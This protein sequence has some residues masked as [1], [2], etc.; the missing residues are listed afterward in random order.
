MPDLH[1]PWPESGEPVVELVGPKRGPLKMLGLRMLQLTAQS[2]E[3]R[4]ET[5]ENEAVLDIFGGLCTVNISASA[6]S[7][8]FPE[9]G[10]RQN[11]FA[12]RPTMV[13]I[14]K[15]ARVSVFAESPKFEA[16]L[17]TAPARRAY[18]PIDRYT[19]QA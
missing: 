2:P 10:A 13:Y 7:A 19:A 14:P 17:V 16:A 5:G 3:S 18:P 4:F 1:F 6:G 8:T 11:V 12:G 15:Q 9:I